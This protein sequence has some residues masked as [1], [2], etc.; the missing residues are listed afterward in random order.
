MKTLIVKTIAVAVSV[1]T[2]CNSTPVEM[3]SYKVKGS[4]AAIVDSFTAENKGRAFYEMYI[5]K[6]EPD[7]VVIQLNAADLPLTADENN[8]YEQWPAIYIVSN[9]VRVYVYSGL[10]RYVA[11]GRIDESHLL[12]GTE[13]HILPP[14]YWIIT[15]SKGTV[16]VLKQRGSKYIYL[17]IPKQA[18]VKFI[19][20]EN[21]PDSISR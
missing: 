11:S 9:G 15:D 20:P 16:S 12:T 17:S 6:I 13:K 5:D 14:A 21:D 18:S 8:R 1:L 10:E 7:S 2:S 3:E 19:P 4:I